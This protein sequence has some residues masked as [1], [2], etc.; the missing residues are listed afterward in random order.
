MITTMR[1][2]G[3]FKLMLMHQCTDRL[4]IVKA[5]ELQIA[6]R[7]ICLVISTSFNILIFLATK[8]LLQTLLLR[9][10]RT[11][12]KNTP[13]FAGHTFGVGIRWNIT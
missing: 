11:S 5:L 12:L 7:T 13:N 4:E 1:R 10:Y 2:T 3:Q 6:Y 8:N 9:W